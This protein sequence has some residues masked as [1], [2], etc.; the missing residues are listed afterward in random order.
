MAVSVSC[1]AQRHTVSE[2][3]IAIEYTPQVPVDKFMSETT[4]MLRTFSLS[5]AVNLLSLPVRPSCWHE[6]LPCTSCPYLYL[7]FVLS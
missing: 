1:A 4:I 5:F 7:S 3:V 6:R 2:V